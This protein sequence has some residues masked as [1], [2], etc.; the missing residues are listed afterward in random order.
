MRGEKR[1]AG[2]LT[3]QTFGRLTVVSHSRLDKRDGHI[4]HCACT[5][6]NTCEKS[7]GRLR[8][9]N[10]KTPS[11]GCAKKDAILKAA[12]AAWKVTTKFS[13]PLKPKIKDLYRNMIKRCGDPMDR[14]YADYGGRGISVCSEW[15]QDRYTFYQWCLD[16]GIADGLM[17]DRKDNNGPYCPENCKF[18]TGIEQANN[19]RKNVFLEWD[20]KLLTM[21]QWARELKIKPSIIQKRARL[22]WPAERILTQPI[23]VWPT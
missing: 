17:L 11:C 6:G 18:S 22:G 9:K 12:A 5:C 16:N 23:R 1:Y 20:G 21:S 10:V 15:V 19:T 14:R 3:G 4:W 7:S 13:H 2:N 8:D